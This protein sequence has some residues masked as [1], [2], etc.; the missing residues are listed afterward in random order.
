MNTTLTTLSAYYSATYASLPIYPFQRTWYLKESQ[1][2][3]DRRLGN[4]DKSFKGRSGEVR[5]LGEINL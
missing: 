2:Q 1:H 3:E 4:V 5:I